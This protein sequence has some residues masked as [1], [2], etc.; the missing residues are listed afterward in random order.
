MVLRKGR[1]GPFWACPNYPT[2]K[3]I[4][5]A[6]KADA[7]PAQPDEPLDEKC[8]VCGKNFVKRR[9]RYGEFI[10]CIDYPKCKTTKQETVDA[11]CPE[12]GSTPMVLRKGRYGPFLSCSKYPKCK[13]ILKQQPK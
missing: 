10:C 7:P 12:C 4:V 8:H 11:T 3:G 1:F 13:G 2:C 6:G 5:K 9:G